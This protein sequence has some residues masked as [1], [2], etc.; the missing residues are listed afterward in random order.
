MCF[1]VL[2]PLISTSKP[3]LGALLGVS[4]F[5]TL[6]MAAINFQLGEAYKFA[7]G[8]IGLVLCAIGIYSGFAFLFEDL[9]LKPTPLTLRIGNG[10]LAIEG[11]TE[12]QISQLTREV[13][14]RREL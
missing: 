8:I 2:T 1:L 10:R 4:V 5:R 3:L 11:R 14:I 12:D 9:H 6:G 7:T 13:G